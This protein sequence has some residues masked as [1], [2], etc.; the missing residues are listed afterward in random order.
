M[1]TSTD[2]AASAAVAGTSWLARLVERVLAPCAVALV[3]TAAG[4][5]LATAAGLD[6]DALFPWAEDRARQLGMWP[7]G[8]KDC[9]GENR[10]GKA[11][12]LD[13]PAFPSLL[14]FGRL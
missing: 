2:A 6:L 1:A 13:D 12:G 5:V 4:V 9:S 8:A 3:V 10:E 14:E 11:T 7:A